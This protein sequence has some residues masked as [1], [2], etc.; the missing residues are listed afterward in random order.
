MSGPRWLNEQESRAWRG[1]RRMQDL[2]DLQI[3]RDLA[4]DTGLSWADY[5]VLVVLSESPGHRMRQLDL[6]ARTFWSKS[7]LSH[8]L[9]RME[10]RGLV[11]REE[12]A[13]NSRA[14][15]AVLTPEGLGVI[16]SAAP[17]HLD[18]V[19]RHFIDLLTEDQV[20]AI[21][22]AAETIVAHLRAQGDPEQG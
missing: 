2:L 14:I 6:A 7:R 15:D 22:D 12:Q 13:G 9:S 19:R 18:S 5:T 20:E 4:S 21:G 8:Q 10:D 1:Y 17:K 11:R 16:E 3:T